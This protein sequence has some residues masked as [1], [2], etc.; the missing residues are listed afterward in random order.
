MHLDEVVVH[1]NGGLSIRMAM[2]ST[3]SSRSAATPRPLGGY[4]RTT[5]RDIAADASNDPR[6]VKSLY[7]DLI[8]PA[9]TIA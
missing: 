1:I 2:F 7:A 6:A 3:R 5:I 9:N 8:R 4:E